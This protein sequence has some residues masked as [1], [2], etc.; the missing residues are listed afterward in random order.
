MPVP[1]VITD[2]SATPG[3]NSPTVGESLAIDYLYFQT[4]HA[5]VRQNYN[6]VLANSAALLVPAVAAQGAGLVGYAEATAYATAGTLGKYLKD[7]VSQ[8]G[9]R[10]L[11]IGSGATRN[12]SGADIVSIGPNAGAAL[13]SGFGHVLIG[14]NAGKLLTTVGYCVAI[15]LN[16]LAAYDMPSNVNALHTAVGAYALSSAVSGAQYDTAVG[17]YAG[18]KTTT[19]YFDTFIGQNCGTENTVGFSN[20][21]VGHSAGQLITGA[22]NWNT[23]IGDNAAALTTLTTGTCLLGY[24]AGTNNLTGLYLHAFGYAAAA[25]STGGLG[26]AFGKQAAYSV[27]ANTGWVAV[28]YEAGINPLGSNWTAVGHQAM[29]GAGA[30]Y[31]GSQTAI[32]YR[33]AYAN[34]AAYDNTIALG[35]N[36]TNTRSNQAWIGDTSLVEM[37]TSAFVVQKLAVTGSVPM[38]NNGEFAFF[39]VDNTHVNFKYR[40]TDGTTRTATGA[41][42]AGGF[43][44]A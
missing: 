44:L 34:A 2:L 17:A 42:A 39:L 8:V 6:L 12:P 32:G 35:S 24:S 7:L 30:N 21:Y 29:G 28:G 38:D 19:G 20:T 15:G 9:T 27:L 26:T 14:V 31:S 41:F 5:F 11:A 37:R 40:G 16:A 23:I 4:V 10:V 25:Q 33:A 1:S 43:V 13:T 18:Q 22:S 3:A 36:S